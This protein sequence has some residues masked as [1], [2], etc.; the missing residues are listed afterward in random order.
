MS[1]SRTVEL[2]FFLGLN[3]A[4]QLAPLNWADVIDT[5]VVHGDED[6]HDKRRRENLS[7]LLLTESEEE[8]KVEDLRSLL[9]RR[10]EVAPTSSLPPSPLQTAAARARSPL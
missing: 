4:D 8:I 10:R 5:L 3:L 6:T 2:L 1:L 9:W 7:L